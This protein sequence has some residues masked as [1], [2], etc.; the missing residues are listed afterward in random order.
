[1][2]PTDPS[3]PGYDP[4]AAVEGEAAAREENEKVLQFYRGADLLIHDSQYTRKE[5]LASKLGWGHTSFET[6]I[7]NAHKAGVKHLLLFHHD[8]NRT[9]EELEELL[10]GYRK[11]L[12]GK[13]SLKIDIAREGMEYIL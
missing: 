3:Q 13:S 7:N 8:P 9:D 10:A 5:Y 12:A 2:F 6:A 11:R 1:V 4:E